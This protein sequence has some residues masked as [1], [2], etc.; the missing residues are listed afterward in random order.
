GT[1]LIRHEIPFVWEA[2]QLH[3]SD[4]QGGAFYLYDPSGRLILTGQPPQTVSLENL[5]PGLYLLQLGGQTYRLY[6]WP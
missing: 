4:S 3:I 5:P 6:R 1:K 2:N